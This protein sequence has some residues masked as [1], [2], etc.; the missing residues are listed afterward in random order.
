MF[1]LRITIILLAWLVAEIEPIAA[2]PTP[3]TSELDSVRQAVMAATSDTA[4]VMALYQEARLC[5]NAR[6]F[7]AARSAITRGK[8]LAG[9]AKFPKGLAR[10][11]FQ[12]GRLHKEQG[13]LERGLALYQKA[14]RGAVSA[15]DADLEHTC[16]NNMATIHQFLG[17]TDSA[18][19]YL[20]RSYEISRRLDPNGLT[21]MNAFLNL[22]TTQL[23]EGK[24]TQALHGIQKAL[25]HPK[26][27]TDPASHIR[28]LSNLSRVYIDLAD[29]ET[30]LKHAQQ[31][32]AICQENPS[33]EFDKVVTYLAIGSCY[34][35]LDKPDKIN[36]SFWKAHALATERQFT[37]LVSMTA[38]QLATRHLATHRMDSV[39]YY[40]EQA[41]AAAM[42]SNN[43]EAIGTALLTFSR[44]HVEQGNATKA[45]EQAAA[46]LQA[47]EPFSD[48]GVLSMCHQVLYKSDSISGD[49][50]SSLLHAIQ[51]FRL[52]EM[53]LNESNAKE[54]G[55]FEERMRAEKE[56][57][58]LRE[59][60]AAAKAR[61]QWILGSAAGALLFLSLLALTLYRGR[62]KE[63]RANAQLRALNEAVQQQ[64]SEIEA[65]NSEI[66]AQRD[67]LEAAYHKLKEVDRMKEELSGMIVHDLKNPLNAVLG[68]SALPAEEQ[69]L[70]IIRRAGQQM[71]QL[72][73]NLLDVQRYESAALALHESNVPALELIEAARQQTAF[74]A[75]EKNVTFQV[76]CLP[77]LIVVCDRDLIVRVWVN[78]L[79]NAIKHAPVGDA[80][81]LQAEYTDNQEALFRLTDHGPGIPPDRLLAVFDKF[82]QFDAGQQSG[83]LRGTGLGL[84]FCRMAVQSH[85]GKISVLSAPGQYT[86]FE[87]RLP[88]A[89]VGEIYAVEAKGSTLEKELPVGWKAENRN[90][91]EQIAK[92]P[93][94]DLTAFYDSLEQLSEP[95]DAVTAWKSSLE[96]ATL[97]GDSANRERLL[98]LAVDESE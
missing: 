4:R 13:E 34:E 16:S 87:F 78:L 30:A 79:T 19:Y 39:Q 24:L 51:F 47:L 54:S 91:I 23:R 83:R 59:E 68:L 80:L 74:L 10:L 66:T 98:K 97:I 67:Q 72:V 94:Y 55:R 3:K 73:T 45:R 31:A 20:E 75:E 14:M 71:A 64:K 84:A 92:L 53:F 25:T 22:N 5:I 9:R 43:Q 7:D 62:R 52:R 12:E 49:F 88:K 57:E 70:K 18:L 33:L 56:K 61:N 29:Y 21:W 96:H 77:G 63:R 36:E 58:K 90:L 42:A 35:M 89:G 38:T 82:A 93:A 44:Y 50:R 32:L 95:D 11:A 2:Q 6:D 41:Y 27:A 69:R 1:L 60:Q 48:S 76:E 40:A 8:A 17:H 85:G 46:A 86:T 28:V 65:Q 15:G 81:V 26:I 37:D